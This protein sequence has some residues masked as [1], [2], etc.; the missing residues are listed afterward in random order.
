MRGISRVV[1]FLVGLFG[2]FLLAQ[3]A[4]AGEWCDKWNK[5]TAMERA[6]FMTGADAR[7]LAQIREQGN[8]TQDQ[9]VALAWCLVLTREDY[10]L[11]LTD[12]CGR[13][14]FNPKDQMKALVKSAIRRGIVCGEQM[15]ES[16]P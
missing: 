15:E 1:W 3:S 6:A 11:L 14:Y 13:T 10:S 8:L 4:M 5:Q 12:I 2:V 9:V 16:S 7:V